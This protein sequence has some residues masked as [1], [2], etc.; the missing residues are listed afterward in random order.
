MYPLDGPKVKITRKLESIKE[1]PYDSDNNGSG[2][3]SEKNEQESK[4]NEDHPKERYK[5]LEEYIGEEYEE[6]E[7]S[8]Q[9]EV[10]QDEYFSPSV[11]GPPN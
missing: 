7:G 2:Q 11:F 9:V 8:P 4:S 5:Y 3:S 6:E 10:L 1:K